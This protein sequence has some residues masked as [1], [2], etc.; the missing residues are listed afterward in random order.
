[1]AVVGGPNLVADGLVLYLDAANAESY[2]G[3]GST[4]YDLSGNDNHFTLYNS[5][6]YSS[7]KF[8]FDGVN[9]FAQCNNTTCGNFGLVGATV[10][11]G[12]NIALPAVSYA[13]ITM[14]RG[15]ITSIGSP[16]NPG[17]AHRTTVSFFAHD[18]NPGGSRDPVAEVS[19]VDTYSSIAHHCMTLS[20][21]GLNYV[22]NFYTNNISKGSKSSAFVGDGNISNSVAMTIF[23]TPGENTYLSG[24]FYFIRLYNRQLSD[25]EVAQNYSATRSR[26]G[27]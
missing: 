24:D 1:M 18:N 20:R 22:M 4:W 9:E 13:S 23:Y 3:S 17:W 11:Y 16:S 15:A 8:T 19:S 27:L 6:T 10:E 2:P 26:F 7:G 14:K 12:V 25:A 5:P 21:S